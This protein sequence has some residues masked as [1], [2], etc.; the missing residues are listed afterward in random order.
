M[1]EHTVTGAAKTQGY[2]LRI[3]EEQKM[4]AHNADCQ[5]VG[6][7]FVPMVVETLGGWSE[8]AVH[9]IKKLVGFLDNALARPL[10]K[11]H[12][13]YFKDYQYPFGQQMQTCGWAAS[14]LI[15]PHWMV[16]FNCPT[17][18]LIT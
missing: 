17:P 7:T 13:I 6:V 10:Q 16:T 11:P 2:A 8:E 1:Q 15:W 9:T 12:V 3:V 5:A 14:H 18:P 4:A